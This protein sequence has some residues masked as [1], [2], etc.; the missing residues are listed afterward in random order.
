[1]YL[2]I[3]KHSEK[4]QNVKF[5]KNKI[6]FCCINDVCLLYSTLNLSPSLYWYVAAWE[7]RGNHTRGHMQ[8]TLY[9]EFIMI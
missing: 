5:V 7:I 4:M 9:H 1:M 6:C 8:V 2:F 3:C